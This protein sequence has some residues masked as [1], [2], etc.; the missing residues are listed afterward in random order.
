[1]KERMEKA[2]GFFGKVLT[3]KVLQPIQA[4]IAA[5]QYASKIK[6]YREEVQ[7]V[8]FSVWQQLQKLVTASWGSLN[9]SD[10]GMYKKFEP[11]KK[12]KKQDIPKQE[13]ISSSQTSFILFREGKTIDE[14]ASLRNMTVGTIQTHLT[15]FVRSGE[16]QAEELVPLERL[17]KII[18]LIYQE[19]A[20]SAGRIKNRLDESFSYY[21]V[22][23]AI[24]QFYFLKKQVVV[25][26]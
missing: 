1:M 23:V 3:D 21:E 5:L 22:R 16:I 18:E 11:G 20:E 4:H 19:G 13:K 6:K 12:V 24:N 7:A 25:S 17:E 15:S 9:F 14:I 2:A 8:E 26:Q 10:P